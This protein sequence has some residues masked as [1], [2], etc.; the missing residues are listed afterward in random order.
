MTLYTIIAEIGR[1]TYIS[2]FN[3]DDHNGLLREWLSRHPSAV[4]NILTKRD[5]IKI[6]KLLEENSEAT[7]LE[8]ITGM[9]GVWGGYIAL[10]DTEI[11]L[12]I[13]MTA[14]SDAPDKN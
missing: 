13:V 1:G 2:Q 6:A 10:P 11:F 5:K 4:S 7:S 8:P 12:H 9:F 14:N 3:V